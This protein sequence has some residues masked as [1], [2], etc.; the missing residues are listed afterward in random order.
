ML[1]TSA[2]LLRDAAQKRYALG[3][4]DTTSYPL[5]E[6]ILR[7]AEE[8]QT[9]LIMMMPP[10]A[11]GRS[12]DAAYTRHMV[13]RCREIQTPVALHLDHAAQFEQIQQAV[14]S[15]FS[16]VMIDA[17]ALP[18]EKNVE[19]T[20]KVVRYAHDRGVSVEAEIGHVGG[21]EGTLKP[22]EADSSGYTDPQDAVKFVQ[23]TGVDLLAVA[24]GTVHGSFLGKPK[25]DLPRLRTI[26]QL[27]PNVPLVMHGGSGLSDEDFRAAVASGVN[28]VNVFTEI[29]TLYTSEVCRALGAS[30]GKLHLHNAVTPA[31]D[32]VVNTIHHLM[33]VFGTPHRQAFPPMR[34]FQQ[35]VMPTFTRQIER[36]DMHA[37]MVKNPMCEPTEAFRLDMSLTSDEYELLLGGLIPKGVEEKWQ[38]YVEDDTLFIHRSWTGQCC[39]KVRIEP[40]LGGWKLTEARTTRVYG[41]TGFDSERELIQTL[42]SSVIERNAK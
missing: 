26:R 35:L 33:G 10:F 23:E 13:E 5:T 11:Y 29:S 14:E 9:P 12:Y 38:I 21:G 37:Y 32:A 30:S 41:R 25:L 27:L 24:F 36:P 4:F 3:A 39:Y 28:K 40:D 17:S 34:P 6:A 42:V 19:M 20:R 7:A 8:T 1:V 31:E 18:F 15:G 22:A 16:S 2:E